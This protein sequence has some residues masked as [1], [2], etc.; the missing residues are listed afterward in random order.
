MIR[1]RV[2]L[3]A[4]SGMGKTRAMLSY[5]EE[6]LNDDSSINVAVIDCDDSMEELLDGFP[7][8][9][10]LLQK[11]T[12]WWLVRNY[13]Q[14]GEAAARI[15]MLL[16]EGDILAF[17]GLERGWELAQDYYTEEVFG[18]NPAEQLM[19]IR[20]SLVSADSLKP[21]SYDTARD[22]PTIRKLWKNEV[23]YE[24]TAGVPWH[25]VTTV[26]AKPIVNLGGDTWN[27]NPYVRAIF[28]DIGVAPEGEKSDYKRFQLIVC[29]GMSGADYVLSVAKNRTTLE[30][31]RPKGVKWTN[32]PFW[33][34]TKSVLRPTEIVNS[35]E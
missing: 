21:T 1:D 33:A 7:L 22:W 25:V 13:R 12:N 10:A 23:L 26:S 17:E 28:G 16:K 2:M 8:T 15:P 34:R 19:H 4:D 31:L 6:H 14:L 35:V 29:L 9:K 27:V 11:G 5:I 3:V 18:K 30:A 24:L 32:M 20:K